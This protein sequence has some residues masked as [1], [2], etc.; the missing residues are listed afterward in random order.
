MFSAEY[1][2]RRVNAYIKQ[3]AKL[4]KWDK[5]VKWSGSHCLRHGAVMEA[6]QMGGMDAARARGA[7]R[8]DAT[9][10]HYAQTPAQRA[11]G[12]RRRQQAVRRARQE[13]DSDE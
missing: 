6:W 9:V 1:D 10:R 11:A 5:E 7:Q 3:A 12:T 2:K 4:Y 13:S 8:A